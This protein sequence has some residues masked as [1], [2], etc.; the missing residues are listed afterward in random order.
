MVNAL[1]ARYLVDALSDLNGPVISRLAGLVKT[2]ETDAFTAPKKSRFP[3]PI[4]ST[5]SYYARWGKA[6]PDLVPN[7]KE[8]LIVYFED[9]GAT[10]SNGRWISKLRLIG[11]GNSGLFEN[12]DIN[13]LPVVLITKIAR[14]L[15]HVPVDFYSP[16]SALRCEVVGSPAADTNLFSRY[17]Y[18]ETSSQYLLAPYF[19][20]GLDLTITYVLNDDCTTEL[21]A[22]PVN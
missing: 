10:N 16:V 15:K 4:E 13:L 5:D 12:V 11:W 20:F 17:T 1:I 22:L 8:R 3:A 2:L 19:A 6:F 14:L 18:S 9:F 21:I 7:Q